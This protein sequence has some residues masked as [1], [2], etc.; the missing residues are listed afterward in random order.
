MSIGDGPQL[1]RPPTLNCMLRGKPESHRMSAVLYWGRGRLEAIK[2]IMS[3]QGLHTI[4]V[5][6]PSWKRTLRRVLSS[7]PVMTA[8]TRCGAGACSSCTQCI[9]RP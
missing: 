7:P 5:R 6:P 2:D 8:V 9:S 4:S 1:G 3:T